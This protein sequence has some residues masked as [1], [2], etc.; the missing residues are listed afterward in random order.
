M[1]KTIALLIVISI[2]YAIIELFSL[3][4]YLLRFGSYDLKALHE[5]KQEVIKRYESGPVYTEVNQEPGEIASINPILHP[6]IGYTVDAKTRVED[7]ESEVEE[8]CYERIKLPEDKPFPKRSDDYLIVGVLGGS[9]SSGTVTAPKGYYEH[10]LSRLPEY[11]GKEVIL[12]H[13]ASGGYK[14]PQQ[15][16][17]LAYYIALGAEF[18]LVINIDGFNDMAVTFYGYRDEKLHPVMPMSWNHRVKG[19]VSAEYLDLH[20]E[21]RI[22][23]KQH[24]SLAQTSL[25]PIIRW[26]FLANSL[27]RIADLRYSTSLVDLEMRFTTINDPKKR[28]FMFQELG[29]DFHFTDWP[30]FHDYSAQMWYHSS[31]SMHAL[32]EQNGAKYFHFLQPNQYI[33]GSKP[34]SDWEKKHTIATSGFG[35]VYRM[36]YPHL[37]KYATKL[38]KNEVRFR[39]LS[40]IFADQKGTLY[41]DTCCHLNTKGYALIVDAVVD[42]IAKHNSMLRHSKYSQ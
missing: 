9:V 8:D 29:P 16:M 7:C 21:K 24:T 6:Y 40:D 2:T 26:S 35:I 20:A 5:Q 23:Q 27:W 3:G 19:V 11:Q 17:Q 22:L 41:I 10:A 36:S 38:E 34:L 25:A 15:L 32:A 12:F 37:L 4:F 31:L 39:N 28:D 33:E 1:K 13:M 18:D 42:T 14:Q 30:S